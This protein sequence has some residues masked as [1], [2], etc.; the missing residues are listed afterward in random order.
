VVTPFVALTW[1]LA[2]KLF[3]RTHSFAELK[4][5]DRKL[6]TDMVLHVLF[7]RCHLVAFVIMHARQHFLTWFNV[8][9]NN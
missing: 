2:V 3:R 7:K 5:K 4:R 6:E 9:V 8:E 1:L